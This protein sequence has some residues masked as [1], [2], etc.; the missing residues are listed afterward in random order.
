MYFA[1][2]AL[3][4]LSILHTQKLSLA[5]LV[6]QVSQTSFSR[7][8]KT[9]R[10]DTSVWTDNPLQKAEKEAQGLLGQ[11]GAAP[12]ALRGKR[13]QWADARQG[14]GAHLVGD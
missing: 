7:N 1:H 10:G 8:V 2:L 5:L 4:T 6:L 12:L 13:I 9:G 11:M 3:Y 14:S